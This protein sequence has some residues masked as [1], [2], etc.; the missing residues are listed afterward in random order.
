M[1]RAKGIAFCGLACALCSDSDCP[2]CRDQGCRD[3]DWCKNLQCCK[4]KG[5]EGCWK[6]PEFPCEGTMLDKL[7]ARTFATFARD[8]GTERLLDCLERNDRAGILYHYPGELTGDYDV[9]ASA[10]GI[11]AMLFHGNQDL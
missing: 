9:P 3:R 1:E 2:G 11:V 8:H 5:L 6:C 10:D 4:A 7:R